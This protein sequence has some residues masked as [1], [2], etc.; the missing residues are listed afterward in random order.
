MRIVFSVSATS[1]WWYD[2]LINKNG[3]IINGKCETECAVYRASVH[4][5]DHIK[6]QKY[7]KKYVG[8]TENKLKDR[9]GHHYTDFKHEKYKNSTTLSNYIWH[10]QKENI[11]F[12]IEWEF[13]EKSKTRGK[14]DKFCQ[15]CISEK[16]WIA[17]LNI[18]ERINSNSEFVTKCPHK[19]KYKLA[20][21][22]TVSY[23]HLTLPTKR[24]V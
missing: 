18:E 5:N 15:L 23:T 3:C 13:V 11:A 1:S 22:K 7:V 21:I 19:R 20:R 10:L 8:M 4:V 16:K 2:Y 12:Q 9:I 24:I 14:D 6:N 17:R